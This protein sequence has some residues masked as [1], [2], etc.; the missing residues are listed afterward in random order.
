M[1]LA[2][3][4]KLELVRQKTWQRMIVR[5]EKAPKEM[6]EG[7]AKMLETSATKMKP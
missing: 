5:K 1:S 6:E 7:S 2:G 4:M 3:Q